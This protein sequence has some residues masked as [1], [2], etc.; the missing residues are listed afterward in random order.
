M[1]TLREQ[2]EELKSLGSPLSI[3]KIIAFLEKKEANKEKRAKRSAKVW[4]RREELIKASKENETKLAR[5][6][7]GERSNYFEQIQRRSV[8]NQRPSSL[9]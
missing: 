3:E 4:K 9:R 2:A 7:E 8:L 1:K 6:T 5:M